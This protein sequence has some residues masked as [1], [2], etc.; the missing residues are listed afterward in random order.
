MSQDHG[1]QFPSDSGDQTPISPTSNFSEVSY[2]PKT[3]YSPGKKL[4]PEYEFE[5]AVDLPYQPSTLPRETLAGIIIKRVAPGSNPETYIVM[6][7]NGKVVTAKEMSQTKRQKYRAGDPVS[8]I[9]G[10]SEDEWFMIGN[11]VWEELRTFSCHLGSAS[12]DTPI[13][14][15]MKFVMSPAPTSGNSINS[16]TG[17][18]IDPITRA[19]TNPF[20]IVNNTDL[21]AND[22]GYYEI[23]WSFM[24]SRD[25]CPDLYGDL[26]LNSNFSGFGV[27]NPVQIKFDNQMRIGTQNSIP[28][29]MLFSGN[30]YASYLK[31]N[32]YLR[33]ADLVRNGDMGNGTKGDYHQIEFSPPGASGVINIP[34][35][36][37]FVVDGGV[38]V[39]GPGLNQTNASGGML[40]GGTCL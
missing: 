5:E 19:K 36:G 23:E 8:L 38:I 18:A 6:G 32:Q 4:E 9:R 40:T 37:S 7:E 11:K 24:L 39:S 12:S 10:S 26:Q 22:A 35:V 3:I 16:M 17:K 29:A 31:R 15:A 20:S 25:S 1:D 27:T 33:S 30:A 2:D 13:L 34:S 14:S 28:F 21:I